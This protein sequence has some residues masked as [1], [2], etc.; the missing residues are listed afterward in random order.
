MAITRTKSEYA[1]ASIEPNEQTCCRAV[2]AIA[3]QRFLSYEAPMLPL[4][5][6]DRIEQCECKYQKW[7]DRRQDERRTFYSTLGQ[8]KEGVV[9]KRSNS[10]G[11]RESD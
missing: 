6:C 3:H 9:D 11:R 5:D 8:L 4:E 2:S 1:A 7:N 10:R